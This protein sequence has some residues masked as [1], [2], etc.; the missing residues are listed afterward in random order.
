MGKLNEEKIGSAFRFLEKIKVFTLDRVVSLL[1]C[2]TP[3]TRLKLKQWK[4]HTSFNQNGRY[5][6]MPT[7]PRFDSNG[8]WFHED[9]AFSHHGN[10]RNTVVALIKNSPSGLSGKEIGELVRLMPRSFLHHFR[11]VSGICREKQDGVYIYFSDDSLR[12]KEQLKQRELTVA[13]KSLS[14]TDAIT[15]LAALIKYHRSSPDDIAALPEVR[16]RNISVVAIR[17]FVDHHCL[18]KKKSDTVL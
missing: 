12:Y 1:C 10:L 13:G 2:S 4:A 6:T 5:Y 9:V 17:E 8:L 18:L 14:A 15:I 11:D 3:N 16:A 7:V